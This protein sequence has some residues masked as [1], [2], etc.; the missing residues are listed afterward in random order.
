[1]RKLR[2][3][4]PA[5]SVT[6]SRAWR[7]RAARAA[8][9]ATSP[10]TAAWPPTAR[11]CAALAH[12]AGPEGDRRPAPG[13]GVNAPVPASATRLARDR[14]ALDGA[15]DDVE[16]LHRQQAAGVLLG[17]GQPGQ[18][19]G[20]GEANVGVQEHEERAP[21]SLRRHSST[22][23]ACRPSPGA[24]RHVRTT[25]RRRCGPRPPCRRRNRRRPRRSRPGR[26]VWAA[27]SA[28]STAACGLVAGRE[29]ST[30]RSWTARRS[31]GQPS[32]PGRR[33]S[34]HQPAEPAGGDDGEEI[35]PDIGS[36]ILVLITSTRSA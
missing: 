17:G 8:S 21:S 22:P 2:T 14:Q 28:S 26:R 32:S 10:R 31:S 9:S 33:H 35:G 25:R 34:S 23:T 24:V 6:G 11:Y 1:M 27:R 30:A 15:A 5:R 36:V 13:R 12:Q 4:R 20:G 18:G 19:V 3:S 7:K 29:R 16:G